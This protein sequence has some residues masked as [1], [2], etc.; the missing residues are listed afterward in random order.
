[1]FDEIFRVRIF[2]KIAAKVPAAGFWVTAEE[3]L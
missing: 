2:T 3:A 1:L